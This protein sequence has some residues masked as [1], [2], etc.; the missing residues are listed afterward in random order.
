MEKKIKFSW[1]AFDSA[2]LQSGIEQSFT[3]FNSE[4]N[5]GE[6]EVRKWENDFLNL[7]IKKSSFRELLLGE[8]FLP[9]TTKFFTHIRQ[10]FITYH[11]H[12]PGDIDLLLV[13]PYKPES[14]IA[15]ECKKVNVT[16]S[17][18]SESV[19]KREKIRNAV[20]QVKGL[21]GMGFS[22]VYLMVLIGSY[23]ADKLDVNYLYRGIRDESFKKVYNFPDREYLDDRAGIIFV[24]IVQ[25]TG[26]SINYRG[27][28]LVGIDR[29]AQ[30][31]AQPKDI[32]L[33]I[34]SLLT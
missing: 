17:I 27:V 7:L 9:F 32:T 20:S 13:D 11:N 18:G 34:K 25:P 1:V 26:V 33:K 10:P 22:K 19:N 24:E 16:T 8:L 5:I 30:E 15:I 12:K 6:N 29:Y 3:F 21:I 23:G 31:Q 2:V 4:T 14:A 28:F